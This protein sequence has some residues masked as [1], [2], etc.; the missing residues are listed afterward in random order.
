MPHAVVLLLQAAHRW[1][2]EHDGQLPGSYKERL[3]FKEV[4]NSMRRRG[5]EG[6][7]FDVRSTALQV[8]GAAGM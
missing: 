5:P 2:A 7:P 4:L 1:R 6:V 3:A 8:L